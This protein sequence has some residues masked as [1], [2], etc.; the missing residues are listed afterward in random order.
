M[1]SANDIIAMQNVLRTKI[2]SVYSNFL[3]TPVENEI[4][5]MAQSQLQRLEEYFNTFYSHHE[6]ILKT[7]GVDISH[8]YFTSTFL[9]NTEDY[10]YSNKGHF[11]D[12]LL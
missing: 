6:L 7:K 3:S 1:A 4:R 11:N 2:K 12:L 8:A 10:Y 5:G 9:A